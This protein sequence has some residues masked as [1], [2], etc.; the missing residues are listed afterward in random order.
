MEEQEYFHSQVHLSVYDPHDGMIVTL[1]DCELDAAKSWRILGDKLEHDAIAMMH[2]ID[3]FSKVWMI[4]N[5]GMT[6]ESSKTGEGKW[7]LKW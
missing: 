6:L 2:L 5:P 1:N 7:T 4:R 3:D